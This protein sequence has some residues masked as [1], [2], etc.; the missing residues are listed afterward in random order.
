MV[1]PHPYHH[2]LWPCR[3][4][5]HACQ[6]ASNPSSTLYTQMSLILMTLSIINSWRARQTLRAKRWSPNSRSKS[7]TKPLVLWQIWRQICETSI[8]PSHVHVPTSLRLR[9][10][11]LSTQE[12]MFYVRPLFNSEFGLVKSRGHR[13]L[14]R[15]SRTKGWRWE[16]KADCVSAF[17][18]VKPCN[19]IALFHRV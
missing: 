15:P 9:Q 11:Q 17:G 16:S 8:P 14:P 19:L 12:H 10:V 5:I 13:W 6:R 3:I 4:N 2:C 1:L 7:Q 18:K